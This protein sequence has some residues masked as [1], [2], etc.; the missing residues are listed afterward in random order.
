MLLIYLAIFSLRP[1]CNDADFKIYMRDLSNF[2]SAN[3]I[4]LDIN[5]RSRGV[6]LKKNIYKPFFAKNEL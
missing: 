1:Y 4:M 2:I 3:I 6:V 5:N